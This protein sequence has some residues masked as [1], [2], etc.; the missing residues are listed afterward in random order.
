MALKE[1]LNFCSKYGKDY[2]YRP[3]YDNIVVLKRNRKDYNN[4]EILYVNNPNNVLFTGSDFTIEAIIDKVTGKTKD[5]MT[6]N[7][8]LLQSVITV[9]DIFK[10]FETQYYKTVIPAYYYYIYKTYNYTGEY[11]EFHKCGRTFAQGFYKNGMKSGRWV[12]YNRFHSKTE[13]GEYNNSVKVGEW[14]YWNSHN[15]T[16]HRIIDHTLYPE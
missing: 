9:G 4:E 8:I 10:P 15:Y 14:T 3:F 13:E 5:K 1:I 16:I 11:I 6:I 2:V 7:N 12:Y